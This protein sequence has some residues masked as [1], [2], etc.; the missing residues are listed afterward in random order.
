V[1][2]VQAGDRLTGSMR[3][4]DTCSEVSV[5]Q[6]AAEAGLAPGADEQIVAALRDLV[7]DAPSGPVRYVT[8]LPA[9]SVLDG[10]V[11]GRT[12]S[13]LKTYQGT[14]LG[15]YRVGETFV[16]SQVTNHA[17]HYRGEVSPDGTTIE[18]TWWIDPD[19]KGGTRRAEG[20]FTLRRRDGSGEPSGQPPSGPGVAEGPRNAT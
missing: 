18:G 5:F 16:G 15:G 19:P 20:G 14:H 4:E 8:H 12:V 7:P 11:E 2:L 9:D 10:R 17:V 3:D 6:V 1:D 13:F